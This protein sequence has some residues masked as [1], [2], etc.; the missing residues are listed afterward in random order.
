M[1]IKLY[2]FQRQ[3][4]LTSKQ[5][6]LDADPRAIEQIVFQGKIRQKLKLY[7]ILGKI[8]RNNLRILKRNNK[9]FVRVYILLNAIK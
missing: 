1:F 6:V 2:M 8:K 9:G 4:V 7:T 3:L 5:N